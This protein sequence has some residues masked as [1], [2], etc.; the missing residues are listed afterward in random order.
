MFR[1]ALLSLLAL[2]AAGCSSDDTREY[3]LGSSLPPPPDSLVALAS[4]IRAADGLVFVGTIDSTV[5]GAPERVND[6]PEPGLALAYP[7]SVAE[8]TVTD[9]LGYTMPAELTVRSGDGLPE[10]VRADGTAHAGWFVSGRDADAERRWLPHAGAHVLFVV[11]SGDG[12]SLVW[13]TGVE[14]GIVSGVGTVG[15]TDVPLTSL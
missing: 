11:P 14:G 8:V 2:V 9:S 7:T 15:G 12:Y 10:V 3:E 1:V 4:E 13:V 5:P 6:V